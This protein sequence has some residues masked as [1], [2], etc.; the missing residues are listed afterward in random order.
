MEDRM[1]FLVAVYLQYRAYGGPEEG[2]WWF[3][4]GEH[5]RTMRV[6]GSEQSAISYC[7]RLNEKLH[8]TLNRGRREVGSV[9]SDGRYGAEV[10]DGHAPPVY[11]SKRPYYS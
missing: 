11:P 5:V 10:H 3:D 8:G 2:G 9:L 6:F 4:C 1:T 7:C